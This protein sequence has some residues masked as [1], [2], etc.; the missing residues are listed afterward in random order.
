MTREPPH[1]IGDLVE[2]HRHLL[3]DIFHRHG[4]HPFDAPLAPPRAPQPSHEQIVR[5]QCYA[6][7]RCE[8]D[9][10]CPFIGTCTQAESRAPADQPV[11]LQAQPEGEPVS[12]MTDVKD[13]LHATLARLETLDEDAVSA[14]EGISANPGAKAVFDAL[15]AVTHVSPDFLQLAANTLADLGT[16]FPKPAEPAPAVPA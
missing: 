11:N 9:P 8:M 1:I 12:L 4:V 7:D 15:A 5:S 14:L 13:G 3:D 2:H 10:A 16:M 6:A